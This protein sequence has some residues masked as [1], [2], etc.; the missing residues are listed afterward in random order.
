MDGTLADTEEIHRQAFNRAFVECDIPW[1]WSPAEYHDLLAISGGRE[2]IR[3]F[4]MQKRERPRSTAALRQLAL[5]VHKRKSDIYRDMLCAGQVALRPGVKRL[6]AEAH[7]RNVR[8]AI[9]TSS[10]RRNVDA[11]LKT[12]LGNEAGDLFRAF[13]TCD[14]VEDQKPSPAIYQYALAELGVEPAHAMAIEDSRNGN[15]AALA[16]GL[17]TVITTHRYT[18]D[19]DFR[20][21]ALVLDHLGEPGQP[22]HVLSGSAHG[23]TF[24]DLELLQRLHAGGGELQAATGTIRPMRS[25]MAGK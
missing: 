8:L 17:T 13:A 19:N 22:F 18:R 10:S 11:L 9:A 21:A 7:S 16:A 20:G 4:L 2:R 24:V 1:Q 15:L 12:T 25:A 23:A 3:R 5:T 14:V 6:L